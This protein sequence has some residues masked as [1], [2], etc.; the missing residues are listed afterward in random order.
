[1]KSSRGLGGAKLSLKASVSFLLFVRLFYF[2]FNK[3]DYFFISG[4]IEMSFN[5]SFQSSNPLQSMLKPVFTLYFSYILLTAELAILLNSYYMVN[6]ISFT[7]FWTIYFCRSNS[8]KMFFLNVRYSFLNSAIIAIDFLFSGSSW[9]VSGFLR[10]RF[11]GSPYIV[12]VFFSISSLG[13]DTELNF[14]VFPMIPVS[15]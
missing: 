13:F 5:F 1:M 11:V 3:L 9:V 8:S 6:I 12:E 14:I 4:T 2:N 10:L 15:S 7:S